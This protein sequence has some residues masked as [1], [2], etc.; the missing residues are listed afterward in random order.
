M[1]PG[2]SLTFNVFAVGFID[3]HE[4]FV[5]VTAAGPPTADHVGEQTDKTIITNFLL[6]YFEH[7]PVVP[8]SSRRCTS[9]LSLTTCSMARLE[10][11]WRWLI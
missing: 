9:T 5:T 11:S 8:V 3:L 1:P 4:L 7:R 10:N 2:R 6:F